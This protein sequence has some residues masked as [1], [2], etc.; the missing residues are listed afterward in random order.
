MNE[1]EALIERLRAAWT[2]ADRST[3]GVFKFVSQCAPIN[4]DCVCVLVIG[5][6]TA[7]VRQAAAKALTG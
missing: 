7:T 6:D 3:P 4:G 1:L 5:S 2:L